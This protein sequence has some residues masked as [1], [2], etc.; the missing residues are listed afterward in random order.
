MCNPHFLHLKGEATLDPSYYGFYVVD[1]E[2]TVD[3]RKE[4][5]SFT[6]PNKSFKSCSQCPDGQRYSSV[7]EAREHLRLVHF[8][9]LSTTNEFLALWIVF[10][11]H[12]WDYQA[13]SDAHTLLLRLSEHIDACLEL[14]K[15]I[16]AGVN[17][18]DGFDQDRYR[19]PASLLGAFQRFLMLI[20]YIGRIRALI[21]RSCKGQVG[22][23]PLIESLA[24]GTNGSDALKLGTLYRKF[25]LHLVFQSFVF[26]WRIIANIQ[27]GL[28]SLSP[29]S[30]KITVKDVTDLGRSGVRTRCHQ[31]AG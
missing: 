15:E 4:L 24:A 19:V 3:Q 1:L 13:F 2:Q 9:G 25:A 30:K 21:R 6:P 12:L 26:F 20:A 29:S 16:K 5:S 7:S 11:D 23:M 22:Y 31:T 14:A 17:G 27:L 18:V 28:Q 10:G 8:G